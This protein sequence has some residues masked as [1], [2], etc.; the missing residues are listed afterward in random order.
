MSL[1]VKSAF[2]VR[3]IVLCN[4]AFEIASLAYIRL[5]LW[6]DKDIDVIRQR[7][8]SPERLAPQSLH[9]AHTRWKIA[10][11]RPVAPG[12]HNEVCSVVNP[13]QY[14]ARETVDHSVSFCGS[15]E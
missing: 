8:S 6:I 9:S 4:T 1:S 5:A 7:E 11:G 14:E 10:A 3:V 13:Y 15:P 2:V 12:A